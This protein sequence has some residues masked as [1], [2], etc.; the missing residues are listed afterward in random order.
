MSL[1][2]TSQKNRIILLRPKTTRNLSQAKVNDNSHLKIIA[3]KMHPFDRKVIMN[4]IAT[5]PIVLENTDEKHYRRRIILIKN[6]PETYES[7]S[8][9]ILPDVVK[10]Y[11]RNLK[12]TLK[13]KTPL[14]FIVKPLQ[15]SNKTL[16]KIDNIQVKPKIDT[17]RKPTYTLRL[18]KRQYS[19]NNT[20]RKT[21][22]MFDYNDIFNIT[23]GK[24][25]FK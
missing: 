23:A 2:T 19:E 20:K 16:T 14:S 24:L 1:E 25:N 5:S 8:L 3:N 4:E 21:Q 18:L 22:R 11:E 10:E 6:K 17:I 9:M 7:P 12:R 13:A 15:N